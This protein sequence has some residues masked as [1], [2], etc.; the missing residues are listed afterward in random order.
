MYFCLSVIT[1]LTWQF[2]FMTPIAFAVVQDEFH[3]VHECYELY[4]D[5]V[6]WCDGLPLI[7]IFIVSSII[8]SEQVRCQL[9]CNPEVAYLRHG[10]ICGIAETLSPIKRQYQWHLKLQSC[11]DDIWKVSIYCAIH[12][13][14]FSVCIFH[15]I[16]KSLSSWQQQHCKQSISKWQLEEPGLKWLRT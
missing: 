9:S 6:Y 11:E 7:I 16:L 4:G 8:D 1:Q 12:F 13:V 5:D 10:A 15:Q 14:L 2:S 3:P